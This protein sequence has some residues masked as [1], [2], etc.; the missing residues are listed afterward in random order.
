MST[1][2][3][4]DLNV[5]IG[6]RVRELRARRGH[7]LDV[8]AA[9]SGV[10][11]SAIS[12]IERG[13]TSPTAVVLE[14]VATGLGVPLASL[15]DARADHDR[16]SPLARRAE[17]PTWRDP[18]SGYRRRNVSPPNWPSPI[19]IVEVEFPAGAT[20][21]YETAEHPVETHQ[22]VWILSGE[23]ALTLGS[24]THHLE[25]GDCFAMRLDQ[26]TTFHNPTENRARYAVVI[27]AD[28]RPS[29]RTTP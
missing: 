5:R 14:K 3:D 15:F 28:Q 29:R 25:A 23:I 21:A 7:T 18:G 8:L 27:V 1:S 24:E 4:E 2:T 20:V 12:A 11:R 17:Q 6:S 16:P 9:R 26:P 19:R 22:Q 13:A 10:S